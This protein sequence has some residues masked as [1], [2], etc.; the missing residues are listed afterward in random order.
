[1]PKPTRIA[2][3]CREVRRLIAAG[4]LKDPDIATIVG[5]PISTVKSVK[6]RLNR[7]GRAAFVDGQIG[8]LERRMASLER[9][10]STVLGRIATLE[11]RTVRTRKSGVP[12]SAQPATRSC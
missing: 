10:V 11:V 3:I 2:G 12:K 4:E 5:C 8:A 6:A 1:M 9:L 7:P